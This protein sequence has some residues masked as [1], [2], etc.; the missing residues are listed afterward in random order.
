MNHRH[1]WHRQTMWNIRGCEEDKVEWRVPLGQPTVLFARVPRKT[2]NPSHPLATSPCLAARVTIQFRPRF[3][4]LEC[5]WEGFEEKGSNR[6][7]VPGLKL[8]SF[9]FF[10]PPWNGGTFFS[11]EKQTGCLQ[12]YGRVHFRSCITLC[13]NW[14]SWNLG[15]TNNKSLYMLYRI[16]F[17][18]STICPYLWQTEKRLSGRPLQATRGAKP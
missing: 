9:A 5:K 12:F 15:I 11:P 8:S 10:C 13:I 1:H 3:F 4:N 16:L 18:S 7:T 14:S 6:R 17:F 2:S